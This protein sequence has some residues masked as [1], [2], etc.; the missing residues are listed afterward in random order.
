MLLLLLSTAIKTLFTY[1]YN[2]HPC[3][4]QTRIQPSSAA[5]ETGSSKLL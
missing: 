3:H 2:R 1:G 5:Q 4:S